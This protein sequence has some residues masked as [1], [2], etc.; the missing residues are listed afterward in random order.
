MRSSNPW[1]PVSI[2][3]GAAMIAWALYAA[4]KP[5]SVDPTSTTRVRSAPEAAMHP[6]AAVFEHRERRDEVR[7]ST[8][9]ASDDSRDD[10]SPEANERRQQTPEDAAAAIAPPL[11]MAPTAPP[12]IIA[13]VTDDTAQ[14][15]DA[16]RSEIRS[17]CWDALPDGKDT[18]AEVSLG[19]S[20]SFD[21]RGKVIASGVSEN[22]DAARPGVAQCV[23]AIVHGLEIPPPDTNVGVELSITVP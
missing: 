20:V 10:R 22:R 11:A 9:D 1:L 17:Q 15:V 18:P 13:R 2:V 3:V 19:L 21:A 4:L 6:R 8:D 14:A 7:S 12:G 16:V 5:P 23:G